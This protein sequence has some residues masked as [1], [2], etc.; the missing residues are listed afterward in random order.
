MF[1]TARYTS[2]KTI[3]RQTAV[4]PKPISFEQFN[5]GTFDARFVR[6]RGTVT[7]TF[8]DELDPAWI[9]LVLSNDNDIVY[10]AFAPINNRQFEIE[11]LRGCEI[12]ISGVCNPDEGGARYHAAGC[13]S[14]KTKT[15]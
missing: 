14:P 4:A 12:V 3:S 8:R 2:I 11:S 10:V 9:Y 15:H 5:S 7:D 6:M 13:L 1:A